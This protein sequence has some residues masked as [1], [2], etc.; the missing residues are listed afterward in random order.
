MDGNNQFFNTKNTSIQDKSFKFGETVATLSAIL[1]IGAVNPLTALA[2]TT[3]SNTS[4]ILPE[5]AEVDSLDYS[6]EKSG[7]KQDIT[8]IYNRI[9]QLPKKDTSINQNY[10]LSRDRKNLLQRYG[11]N[12]SSKYYIQK[13]P[14]PAASVVIEYRQGKLINISNTPLG[15]ALDTAFDTRFPDGAANFP[16]RDNDNIFVV[17]PTSKPTPT[18]PK[19]P[20]F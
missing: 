6:K 18:L 9:Q 17:M 19:R 13:F 12:K 3:K 10:I 14:Y 7:E 20:I 11:Y 4:D 8:K 2:E 16:G 1:L 15:G 5:I